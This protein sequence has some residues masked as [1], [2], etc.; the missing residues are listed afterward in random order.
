MSRIVGP[1]MG[2]LGSA[3]SDLIGLW[4]ATASTQPASSSQAAVTTNAITAVTLSSTTVTTGAVFLTATAQVA[5]LVT[6][7][8]DAI[9]R[10]AALTTLVNQLRT[11]LIAVGAIKGSA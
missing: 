2:A 1:F 4:G 11:D 3:T 9:T 6:A 5:A 10:T 7:V 8:N